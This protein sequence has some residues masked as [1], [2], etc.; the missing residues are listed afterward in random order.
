MEG[1]DWCPGLCGVMLPGEGDYS[2][3]LWRD[4]AGAGIVHDVIMDI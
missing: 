3:A 1:R 2:V 4:Y